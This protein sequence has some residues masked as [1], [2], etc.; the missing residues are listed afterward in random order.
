MS[1]SRSVEGAPLKPPT[2]ER[3]A[4]LQATGL[5]GAVAAAPAVLAPPAAAAGPAS[6]TAADPAPVATALDLLG[7]DTMTGLAVFVMPG[8]DPYSLVQRTPRRE[9]GGVEA[10]LPQFLVR[11]LNR[12]V[13]FPDQIAVPLIRALS[14]G[15]GGLRLP[16]P[17][18]SPDLNVTRVNDGL[19]LLLRNDA[20]VPLAPVVALLLNLEAV[21]VDPRT[22]VGPF[23]SPF[24]RL[25]Y[26]GKAR[27]FEL[28]ETSDSDLVALL[29]QHLPEPYHRSVSGLLKFLGNGLLI[30]A[31]LGGY[32]EWGVFDPET[33]RLRGTPVGW[34]VSRYTPSVDGWDEFKGY[35]QGR[36]E[37][38]G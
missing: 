22:V 10:R 18:T 30:L 20:T 34:R 7:L 1:M 4:F 32:S 31:G 9:P 37:V 13:P 12:F 27:V 6:V 19:D 8:P 28:L 29:D 36:T 21:R 35:Y 24:S 15:A 16:Q 25:S 38:P 23:L 3:R 5:I 2:L 33:K 26:A 14:Q 11:M 17:D